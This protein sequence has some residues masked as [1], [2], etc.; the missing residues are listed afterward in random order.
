VL[1]EHFFTS[2]LRAFHILIPKKR[3]RAV[4]AF[5]SWQLCKLSLVINANLL[6][7]QAGGRYC[8]DRR[9][10]NEWSGSSWRHDRVGHIKSDIPYLLKNQSYMY[11]TNQ[12]YRSTESLTLKHQ[13]S[14]TYQISDTRQI[15]DKT[16]RFWISSQGELNNIFT[17]CLALSKNSYEPMFQ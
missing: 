14:D 10:W 12:G 1:P 2:F 13:I 3:V 6:L 16:C 17:N 7:D 5:N 9:V 15:S 8:S 11:R 4:Q